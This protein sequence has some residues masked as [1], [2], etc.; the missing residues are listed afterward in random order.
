MGPSWRVTAPLA[1][2]YASAVR[3]PAQHKNSSSACLVGRHGFHK[4]PSTRN[5]DA[6]QTSHLARS[7]CAICAPNSARRCSSRRSRCRVSATSRRASCEARGTTRRSTAARGTR[8]RHVATL[9]S[10]CVWLTSRRA[11]RNQH[12]TRKPREHLAGNSSTR[13]RQTTRAGPGFHPRCR[14]TWHGELQRTVSA[15]Y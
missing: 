10:S 7:T 12:S 15:A 8:P 11:G 5:R 4:S 6:L 13:P 1:T 3:L 9:V 14:L 2:P